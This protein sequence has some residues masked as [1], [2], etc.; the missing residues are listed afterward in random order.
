MED[1]YTLIHSDTA[2]KANVACL[3]KGYNLTADVLIGRVIG[4]PIFNIK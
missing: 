1:I 3:V 2:E 4:I